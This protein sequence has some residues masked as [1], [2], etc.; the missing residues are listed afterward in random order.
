M[1]ISKDWPHCMDAQADQSSLVTH[2]KIHCLVT[3]PIYSSLRTVMV[4]PYQDIL[5]LGKQFSY[6][7]MTQLPHSTNKYLQT[8][9]CIISSQLYLPFRIWIKNYQSCSR[10]CT[11]SY[12]LRCNN[13]YNIY[14]SISTFSNI[15]HICPICHT[16]TYKCTPRI[17]GKMQKQ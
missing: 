16:C 15:Y 2:Q 10:Q 1:P 4:T 12:N 9:I 14:H 8:Y 17:S 3:Q 13:N 11:S 7:N 5:V 6:K